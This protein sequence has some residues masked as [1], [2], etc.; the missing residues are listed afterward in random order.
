MAPETKE[1][2]GWLRL[3]IGGLVLGA[4]LNNLTRTVTDPDLWGYLAFGRLFWEGQGFPYQD[5]YAYVP[6]LN[7]WVYHEWLTGV[8]FYPIYQTL[9]AP[10]LQLLKYACG[11]AT[12]GLTYLTART[13]GADPLSVVII[14]W[15]AQM[16]LIIG[17]SPVRAQVFTY[18][19]FALSLYLLES[20]RLWGRWRGLWLLACLQVLWCNLHGGF[21]AGLGLI[22]LYA[23]GEALCR[24]PFK[25]Y[26][27]VLG[28]AVLAT[29]VNPYGL[30]YWEYILRALTMP[31]TEITEWASVYRTL[32][33]SLP[34]EPVFYFFAMVVFSGFLVAWARWREL[35]PGLVL[36]VTLY[37]G[38][39]HLRHV[40]FFLLAAMAYLPLL[41][42]AY[43]EE[44][45][46]AHPRVT[47]AG[48]RL[49]WKIPTLVVICLVV[50]FAYRVLSNSP[51]SLRV[52]PYPDLESGVGTLYYPVGAVDYIQNHKL[53]G[54]LLVDFRWG[55]YALFTLY[56]QCRVAMDG[57]YETVYPDSVVQK[58]WD[59][60]Y[61]RANWRGFLEEFPPDLMLLDTRCKVYPLVLADPEW[62]QVYSDPGCALFLRRDRRAGGG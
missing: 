40:V 2:R 51:L 42:T 57:R 27:G 20:A 17:Y 55:E 58:Y 52:H 4:V 31:R 53:A 16:F 24:R 11:L 59:F 5:I 37:L 23:L 56:P 15:M 1:Q 26:L 19:F 29:L 25:P 33:S 54:A 49:G 3:A 22:G 46:R 32:K 10:A 48:Q 39:K 44:M 45:R 61:G 12:V 7:P 35:T 9:G 13:R 14:L 47:A 38:L 50:F 41:L 21:V 8:L 30:T 28:L 62:R 43:L 6:T 36:A 34:K 60:H 18:A